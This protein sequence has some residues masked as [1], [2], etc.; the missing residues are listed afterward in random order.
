M[1]KIKKLQSVEEIEDVK[2]V[3]IKAE[4]FKGIKF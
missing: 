1:D 4:S 3:I 2:E